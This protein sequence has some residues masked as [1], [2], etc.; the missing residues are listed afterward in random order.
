MSNS[1]RYS[2]DSIL[3]E[4]YDKDCYKYKDHNHEVQGSVQIAE[5]EEDPHNHRFATV[6]GLAIPCGRGDHVH[7]VKFNTDTY[8]DHRHEFCGKT[9][10]AIRVG[11]RHVHFLQSVTT[12]ND[13]HRHCFRVGTL[14]DNPIEGENNNYNDT[15]VR[16]IGYRE[17]R[18]Y[19]KER[20]D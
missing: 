8:E 14:I 9:G 7:E 6:S 19:Y 4:S 3:G 12:V 11:D 13:G 10:G 2:D 20:K 16:A 1:D 18:N 15:R 5:R 17:Y